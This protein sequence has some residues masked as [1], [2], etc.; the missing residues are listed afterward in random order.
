MYTHNILYLYV[1]V[2]IYI[3]CIC[4]IYLYTSLSLSLYIYIYIYVHIHAYYVYTQL[5]TQ[6]LAKSSLKRCGLFRLTSLSFA[7]NWC[8]RLWKFHASGITCCCGYGRWRRRSLRLLANQGQANESTT[9]VYICSL[10]P[11]KYYV[12]LSKHFINIIINIIIAITH[13]LQYMCII[14]MYTSICIY[15]CVYIYI[16]TCIYIYIY[17]MFH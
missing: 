11:L 2:C 3:I 15:V 4:V 14:Y 1:R 12:T 16:Y 10:L 17:I 13:K 6:C 7:E 8:Q 5:P 9:A